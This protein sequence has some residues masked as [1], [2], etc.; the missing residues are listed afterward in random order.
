M[1]KNNKLLLL[2]I[3]LFTSYAKGQ[4]T[5]VGSIGDNIKFSQIISGSD[6]SLYFLGNKNST[7]LFVLKTNLML[8]TLWTLSY[9]RVSNFDNVHGYQIPGS[10][11][12]F[13]WTYD[14]TII[15]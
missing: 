11:N 13:I 12:I 7:N 3:F 14:S 6:S 5:I 1:M 8:D 15:K 10:E 9:D 2:I 4:Q